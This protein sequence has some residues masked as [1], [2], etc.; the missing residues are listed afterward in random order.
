MDI[1]LYLRRTYLAP[2]WLWEYVRNSGYD[3]I[4]CR[5]CPTAFNLHKDSNNRMQNHM[6]EVHY[7]KDVEN[8][9]LL[10]F[11]K[12]NIYIC[13]VESCGFYSAEVLHS[14]EPVYVSIKAHLKSV[15]GCNKS[16][17]VQFYKWL[18]EKNYFCFFDLDETQCNICYAVIWD[19]NQ[20]SLTIHLMNAH[21]NEIHIPENLISKL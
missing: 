11:P 4:A 17:M 7:E 16:K 18:R 10:S 3:Q 21:K 20:I 1:P 5:I 15:H 6:R 12:R 14:H 2:H 8:Y 13:Q 9:Q 19:S